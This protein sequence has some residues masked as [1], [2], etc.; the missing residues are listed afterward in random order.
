MILIKKNGGDKRVRT[1]DPLL[2][3]QVLYQL[4]YIP[5]DK[6]LVTLLKVMTLF[7]KFVLKINKF[8]LFCFKII[9]SFVLAF[10][11]V[12]FKNR[13]DTDFIVSFLHLGL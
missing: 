1:A 12:L 9:I 10:F 3:K 7:K 13:L 2:A 8:F 5:K 6:M 11:N 4:S